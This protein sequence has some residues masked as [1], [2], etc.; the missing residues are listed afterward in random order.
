[1]CYIATVAERGGPA[2]LVEGTD[3]YL[4]YSV[5]QRTARGSIIAVGVR[6]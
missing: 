4:T 6:L 2:Q 1:M 5:V 3:L